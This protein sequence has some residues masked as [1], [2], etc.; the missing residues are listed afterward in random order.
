MIDAFPFLQGLAWLPLLLGGER[1]ALA[2]DY[3]VV[4]GVGARELRVELRIE[5]GRADR[6][7]WG[8]GLSRFVRDV[9]VDEGRGWQKRRN[10]DEGLDLRG[11]QGQPCRV[12]YRFL[13]GRAASALGR[14]SGIFNHGDVVLAPPSRWLAKPS[15]PQE[16]DFF[17]LRVT[18]PPGLQF[19]TGILRS[20]E[21]GGAYE[22]HMVD[23]EETPYGAFGRFVTHSIPVPGGTVELAIG[24]GRW[25]VSDGAMRA[26][27]CRSAKA[28][29]SYFGRFPLSRVLV[30]VLPG[31]GSTV[32]YGT[33]RA[34]SGASILVWV[35]R[36][37]IDDVLAGDWVLT[38]EMIH[39]AFPNL[40]ASQ[41]WM[42]EGLATYVEPIARAR[43]GILAKEEVWK[44]LV[45]G[46]PKG[47]L[48]VSSSGLDGA[49]DFGSLYWGGAL[50]WLLADIEIR[51][52][53]GQTKSL[54]DALRGILAAGGGMAVHWP[55][56]RVLGEGD[57]ATGTPVLKDLY[58]RLGAG[59]ASVD[60]EDLWERLGVHL[61]GG[62][63]RFDEDAPQAYLRR[64]ITALRPLGDKGP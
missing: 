14:R 52:R 2:C 19:V 46:L 55:L 58:L 59:P 47:V 1:G 8:P 45:K 57:R 60:L 35:G 63:I 48:R 51:E 11:C 37:T 4:A 27:G 7:L 33:T 31:R 50:Y 20:S 42:E 39:L 56:E 61:E 40:P 16:G 64:S 32:G 62:T 54:E 22:G 24:A 15:H 6:Y 41:R 49:Q 12:R 26:W 36:E 38:H 23:L 34:G 18:T 43:E 28:V 29:A 44:G 25:V 13:L 9:D 5:A 17:R 30:V 3:R 21:V 53:T 10:A